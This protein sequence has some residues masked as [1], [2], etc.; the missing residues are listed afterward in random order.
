MM[1]PPFASCLDCKYGVAVGTSCARFSKSSNIFLSSFVTLLRKTL[2]KI[3]L[4]ASSKSTSFLRSSLGTS[5][6]SATS[7]KALAR[8]SN[9]N[10]NFSF[11]SFTS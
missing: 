2:V 4:Y 6:T 3:S 10:S 8:I 5:T 1:N 11:N 7:G 9:S